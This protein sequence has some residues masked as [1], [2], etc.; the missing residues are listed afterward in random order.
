MIHITD[1]GGTMFFLNPDAI[2]KMESVPDTVITLQ[3]GNS[4]MV[5]ESTD[6][7]IT[8]IIQF[9]LKYMDSCA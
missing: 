1:M 8:L 4:Y 9:R 3:N 2:E 5:Q 7:I 6:N